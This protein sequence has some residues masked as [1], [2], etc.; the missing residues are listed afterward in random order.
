MIVGKII[1]DLPHPRTHC[2]KGHELTENN[3]FIGPN[4]GARYCIA[5]RQTWKDA[6]Q[7]DGYIEPDSILRARESRARWRQNNPD[8]HKYNGLLRDYKLTQEDYEKL[9]KSQNYKCSI[10]KVYLNESSKPVIDHNHACCDF[11]RKTCGKCVRGVLCSLCNQGLGQFKDDID[12]LI[13]SVEYLTFH[14]KEFV[15]T[16]KP[17]ELI[18]EKPSK[19]YCSFGHE[20]WDKNLFVDSKTGRKTC[21]TCQVQMATKWLDKKRDKIPV[22]GQ[23]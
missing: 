10:C 15:K 16:S 3:I 14:S 23:K 9:L 7:Q 22:N 8:Y 21:R 12:R 2:R 13:S 17:V 11:S 6:R 1:E 4:S 5:C 20:M 19:E 18:T